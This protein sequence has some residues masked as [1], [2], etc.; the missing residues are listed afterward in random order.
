LQDGQA[1][2]H[3]PVKAVTASENLWRETAIE[4]ER[5]LAL[6]SAERYAD[7]L[8][9]ASHL[10]AD[11]RQDVDVQ[12]LCALAHMN[13]RE[14]PAAETVCRSVLG[15]D[16]MNASSYYILALCREH[17]GDLAGAAE[18]DRIAIYLDPTFAMPHM[19]V[20]L[21]ARRRGDGHSARREFEIANLLLA[22]ESASR[23]IMFGGRF[24]RDALRD[25]CR[26][27]LRGLG[28]A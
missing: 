4:L 8:A 9:E 11:L 7:L 24:S 1:S 12:L 26:R 20:A 28:A 17:A 21:I 6:L 22:R 10:P 14:I 27:E 5:L 15:R 2:R 16:S 3:K 25:V 13:R 23:L 18:Q 19:H